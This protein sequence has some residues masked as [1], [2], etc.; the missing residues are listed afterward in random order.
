Q[1]AVTRDGDP[2]R[3]RRA[4]G[5]RRAPG[6]RTGHAAHARRD[7][8]RDR[9]C[10]R[11]HPPGRGAALRDQPDGS[12]DVRRRH[13]GA[14]RRRPAG[15]PAAGAP[16]GRRRSECRLAFRV[17]EVRMESWIQ[18]LKHATRVLLRRPGFSSVAV[19]TLAV[20][21]GANVAIFSVV[22]AVLLRPLPFPD[23]DRL[24]WVW[25]KSP[26]RGIPRR[27]VTPVAYAAYRGR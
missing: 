11:P 16:R 15:L 26:Q 1:P 5:R 25:E 21:I 14:G 24:V 6:R 20:A 3:A 27:A 17:R 12:L 9:S 8:R 23:P 19:S 4:A 22:H 2:D 13:P 10:A 7:D 18:D